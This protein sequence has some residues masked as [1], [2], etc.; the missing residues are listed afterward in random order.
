[1]FKRMLLQWEF[2]APKFHDFTT[3]GDD[4]EDGENMTAWVGMRS[5]WPFVSLVISEVLIVSR[6]G[7]VCRSQAPSRPW[8]HRVIPWRPKRSKMKSKFP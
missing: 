3:D 8:T 6:D 4:A 1:M 5:S 7:L 2:A